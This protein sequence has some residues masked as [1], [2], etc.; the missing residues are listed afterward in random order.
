MN[1]VLTKG[2]KK[3]K[4]NEY[5]VNKCLLCGFL[6]QNRRTNFQ[7]GGGSMEREE[8]REYVNKIH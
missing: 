2:L 7:S 1:R 5:N 6:H 3:R 8:K 4:K